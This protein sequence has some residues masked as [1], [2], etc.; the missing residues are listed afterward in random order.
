MFQKTVIFFIV[1]FAAVIE[2]AVF[3]NFFPDGTAPSVFLALA[4]FWTIK[5]GFE[6]ALSKIIMIG[7]FMDLIYSYPVGINIISVLLVSFGVNYVA[8]RLLINHKT[9]QFFMMAAVVFAGVFG[10]ELITDRKSVV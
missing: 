10:A 5:E 6:R 9:G 1:F 4:V 3:P 2:T 8:K 7:F